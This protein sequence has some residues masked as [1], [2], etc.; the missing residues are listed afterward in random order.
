[1]AEAAAAAAQFTTAVGFEPYVIS[2]TRCRGSNQRESQSTACPGS[3]T[4]EA[5]MIKSARAYEAN[6]VAMNMAR[7]MYSKALEIGKR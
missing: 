3:P 7:Q 6:I 1:M 5:L 4:E 2:N